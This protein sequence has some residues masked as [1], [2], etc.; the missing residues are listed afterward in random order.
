LIQPET[1]FATVGNDRVALP[2]RGRWLDSAFAQSRH[3]AVDQNRQRQIQQLQLEQLQR[4]QWQRGTPTGSYD[5]RTT[6]CD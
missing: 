5:Y 6:T 4:Q 1:Q 3:E 2:G